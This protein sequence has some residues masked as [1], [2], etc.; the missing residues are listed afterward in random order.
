M[1]DDDDDTQQEMVNGAHVPM[2]Y[3]DSGAD[4]DSS[5]ELLEELQPTKKHTYINT[6]V[7]LLFFIAPDLYSST[8]LF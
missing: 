1:I 6:Y 5:G 4:T 2:N 7:C 8:E 3:E